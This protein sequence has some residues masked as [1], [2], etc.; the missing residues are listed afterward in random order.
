MSSNSANEPNNVSVEQFAQLQNDQKAILER[1]NALEKKQLPGQYVSV[2]QFAQL[3]NDQK[4][5]LERINALEKKQLPGQYVSADEFNHRMKAIETFFYASICWGEISPKEDEKGKYVSAE[6]FTQLQNDQ[7]KLLER[8]N[9]LEKQGPTIAM[10]NDQLKQLQNDQKKLLERISEVENFQQQEKYVTV[11]Q[12]QTDQKKAI[13]ERISELEKQMKERVQKQADEETEPLAKKALLVDEQFVQL[14]NDQKAILKRINEIEKKQQPGQY[15]STS[16][17]N[18]HQFAQL[19]ND[20]IFVNCWDANFCHAQLQTDDSLKIHLGTGKDGDRTV[21]AKRSLLLAVPSSSVRF[22][23]EISIIKMN[24]T[25]NFGFGLKNASNLSGT[26][27]AE[28]SAYAYGSRGRFYVNGAKCCANPGHA[29]GTTD[30]LGCGILENKKLLFTKNGHCL[31]STEYSLSPSDDW[32][33][34]FPFVTLI[35]PGD[36][37]EANFGP[38]F[39][40]DLATL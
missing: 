40:F 26:F 22:Y 35:L 33:L 32:A 13:F 38:D 10:I 21:F 34:L 15:A 7:K 17:V 9:E 6:Q 19:Q 31:D 14:Q 36:E 12:F 39:I 30:T 3:Q 27:F 8:V 37:I 18:D 11:E 25:I 24:R 23:F 16:K 29:F 28:T 5:I 20:H 4:A 1:I 2:E